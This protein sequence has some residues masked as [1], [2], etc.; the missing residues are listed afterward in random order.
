MKVSL[1]GATGAIGKQLVPRLVVARHEVHGVTRSESN[2]A[3]LDE[4]GAVSVVADALDPDQVAKA[5]ATAGP[6]VIVHELTAIPVSLDTRHIDRDFALTNRL[7]T[8]GT[9]HL[10]S[11]GQAAGVQRFVAQSYATMV[12]PGKEEQRRHPGHHGRRVR[13]PS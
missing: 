8:E 7:R 10:L 9:D 5:I 13:R 1:A 3:M 6:D 12:R 4:M 11:A 2:K